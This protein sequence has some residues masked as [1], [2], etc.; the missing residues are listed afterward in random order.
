MKHRFSKDKYSKVFICVS[1]VPICV[2]VY[3][4]RANAGFLEPVDGHCQR[5][6]QHGGGLKNN[7]PL[8]GNYPAETR[9]LP[10]DKLTGSNVSIA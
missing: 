4:T 10:L 6:C 5:N 3:K 2:Q 9:L 7:P 1:S 8:S